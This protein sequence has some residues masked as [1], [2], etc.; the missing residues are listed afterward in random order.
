MVSEALFYKLK[1]RSSPGQPDASFTDWLFGEAAKGAQ[2][3]EPLPLL[4][5]TSI[6]QVEPET[7]KETPMVPDL[8]RPPYIPRNGIYQ[9]ALSQVL[10]SNSPGQKRTASARSPSPSH[11]H[12]VR[13]TDLPTGPRAM[14][15]EGNVGH[16]HPNSRSL[17]DRVS[18]PVGHGGAKGQRHDDI[19]ARIDNIVNNAP[20]QNIM[21]PGGFPPMNGM[22]MNPMAMANPLV[23]QEMMMNQMALMAQ[24][25][26]SMGMAPQFNPA[27]P[28]PGVIPG[29]PNMFPGSFPPNQGGTNNHNLN[30]RGRGN[31]R[32]GR[33]G[34]R[35][36][37]GATSNGTKF[38][39]NDGSNT[40]ASPI[41]ELPSEA[42]PITTAPATPV[43][44][45]NPTTPATAVRPAYSVPER[46]QSP[47][48]CKFSLKC[49]NAQCRWSHPSPI[50]TAES[51]VVLS[52]EACESGAECKDK[53]CIKAHVS[54]AVLRPPGMFFCRLEVITNLFNPYPEPTHIAAAS[55]Y[56]VP[57]RFGAAC[58]RA[59]CAFTHP[60]HPQQNPCRF[61]SACTR[62][63]CPFQHPE[64]RVLPSS[65][66]RGLSTS[67]PMVSVNTPETGSMGPSPHRSVTF[68]TTAKKE[69]DELEKRVKELEE[70]K[71]QAEKAVKEAE[72]KKDGTKPVAIAV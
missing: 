59:N 62:A 26:T 56:S 57:C 43:V 30:G 71:S 2:P 49:T 68:N 45:P 31:G 37:G 13:R 53:D 33:G 32:V 8:K 4:P 40:M 41:V 29:D 19:Q 61:G 46:P 22:E 25:A 51:G 44:A 18:G 50:A 14:L 17:L 5:S 24:M 38:G 64:G 11:P 12:K 1:R 10:P 15:R 69:K 48:L 7:I 36:R 20:E 63:N 60:P 34:T 28:M 27:F 72:A 55:H 6:Q 3:E 47:T 65:F 67:S 9:Q 16:G 21:I 66:H 39:D 52:N 35:G 54:P 42:P 23:L 70:K 58:T